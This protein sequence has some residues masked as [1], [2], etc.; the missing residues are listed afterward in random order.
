MTTK[1]GRE[2]LRSQHE[3]EM[4][5]ASAHLVS[6]TGIG[7]DGCDGLRPSHRTRHSRIPG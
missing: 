5:L 4:L 7:R 6:T 3:L 1:I 2:G